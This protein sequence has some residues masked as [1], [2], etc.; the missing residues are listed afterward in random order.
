[1]ANTVTSFDH[2][3]ERSTVAYFSLVIPWGRLNHPLRKDLALAQ[4][5]EAEGGTSHADKFWEWS[6]EQ[7]KPFV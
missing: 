4:K 7:V 3:H 1:M 5:T 6:E 2:K